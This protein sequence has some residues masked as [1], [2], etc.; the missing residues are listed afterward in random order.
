MRSSD[1][2][3]SSPEGNEPLASTTASTMARADIDDR[4]YQE[5]DY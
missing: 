4:L 2:R 3:Q 5:L 1:L